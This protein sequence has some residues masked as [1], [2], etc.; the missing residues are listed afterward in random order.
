L[1]C[2]RKTEGYAN[3]KVENFHTS[4]KS[5]LAFCALIH[6]FR[7]DLINYDSLNPANTEENLR[8]AFSIADRELGIPALLDVEDMIVERPDEKSVMTYVSE[9]FH[10]FS[11]MEKLLEFRNKV[12]KFCEVNKIV[13]E[14]K[15]DYNLKSV[16]HV[17]WLNARVADL[18]DTSKI[19][20]SIDALKQLLLKEKEFS[21]EKSSLFC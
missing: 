7:P 5:G 3:V 12:K 8:L 11:S 21:I 14:G 2:Q 19:V 17:D 18:E 1:W 16:K 15:E 13:S 6:K 10:K 9:Y 20:D 4:F